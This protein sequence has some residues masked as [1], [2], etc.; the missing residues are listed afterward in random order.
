MSGTTPTRD[1][2][3]E[4]SSTLAST[5]TVLGLETMSLAGLRAQETSLPMALLRVCSS[6]KCLMDVSGLRLG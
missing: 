2:V 4:H 1:D 6:V 3:R 5:A